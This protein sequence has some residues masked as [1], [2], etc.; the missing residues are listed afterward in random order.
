MS[1]DKITTDEIINYYHFYDEQGRLDRDNSHKI[2]FLTTVR[3]L[4]RFIQPSSRVLDVSAGAGRYAFYLAQKGHKV[5][6]GDLVGKHV[7][8]MR[9]K[10]VKQQIGMEIFQGNALDLSRFKDNSFDAVLFMGPY[11]HLFDINDRLKAI[12]EAIRVLKKGGLLFLAYLTRASMFMVE[13]NRRCKIVDDNFIEEMIGNGIL[14]DRK[15]S[16]FYFSTPLEIEEIIQNL[17]LQKVSNI[18]T[19][20]ICYFMGTRLNEMSEIEFGNWMKFHYRTC[21]DPHLLGYSLHGLMICRKQYESED[22]S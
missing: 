6:A 7:E 18:A 14:I 2:E 4:D 22:L 17:H 1:N 5:F 13:V 9:D 10:Q 15:E 11:Y 3:Y 12:K 8:Q 16:V 19:D 20:G 21:E